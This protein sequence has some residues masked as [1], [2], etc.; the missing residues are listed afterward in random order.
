MLT[1]LTNELVINRIHNFRSVKEL[2]NDVFEA[3]RDEYKSS[4][5]LVKVLKHEETFLIVGDLHGDLQSLR[6][7]LRFADA[8]SIHKLIFLGDYIDRGE[9]QVET[10]LVPLY[11]KLRY[12]ESIFLLR[13]NHEPPEFLPVYPHDF[14]SELKHRY[15]SVDGGKLYSMFRELFQLMPHAMIL[16][17]VALLLH[18]GP[19]SV[20]INEALT[21]DEYLVGRSDEEYFKVIEE[22]LWNDPTEDIEYTVPSYR[23]AG[24]LFGRKV[25]EAA[26]NITNTKVIVRGHEPCLDGFKTNHS[27]RVITLFSRLGPP[28]HNVYAS[29]MTLAPKL[30]HEESHYLKSI[31]KF[32]YAHL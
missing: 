19:P 27:N 6:Y 16:D 24:Y 11:L 25:T 20:N 13:G 1:D 4:K 14:P 12:P 31:I 15:G 17:D 5:G 8:S 21:M 2:I 22:V 9:N 30:K 23:G 3:L 28:Y 10:I 32:S 29:F 7:I 18:G 26:L